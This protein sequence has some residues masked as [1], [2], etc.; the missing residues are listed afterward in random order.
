VLLNRQGWHVGR[1]LVYRLYKEE[2]LLL[3]KRPPR[4]RKAVRTRWPKL[5]D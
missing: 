1:D 5:E 3:K 2:G 4:R